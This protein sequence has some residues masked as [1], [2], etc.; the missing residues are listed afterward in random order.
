MANWAFNLPSA[1][2]FFSRGNHSWYCSFCFLIWSGGRKN[3]QLDPSNNNG[4]RRSLLFISGAARRKLLIWKDETD[5]FPLDFCAVEH[6]K[7]PGGGSVKF[8]VS[9]HTQERKKKM[10]GSHRSSCDVGLL[11]SFT[12][13]AEVVRP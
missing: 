9:P 8:E 10:V 11:D 6:T 3:K 2:F 13:P 12:R 5:V 4:T 1:V 7:D